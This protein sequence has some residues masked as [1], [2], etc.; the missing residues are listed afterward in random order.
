MSYGIATGGLFGRARAL[1]TPVVINSV[2]YTHFVQFA[3]EPFLGDLA[4]IIVTGEILSVSGTTTKTIVCKRRRMAGSY[5]QQITGQ[6]PQQLQTHFYLG[7][8]IAYTIEPQRYYCSDEPAAGHRGGTRGS[9]A[10][11]SLHLA[12]GLWPILS[13]LAYGSAPDEIDWQG[14]EPEVVVSQVPAAI[15]ELFVRTTPGPWRLNTNDT[16]LYRSGVYRFDLVT[17]FDWVPRDRVIFGGEASYLPPDAALGAHEYWLDEA[18]GQIR[19]SSSMEAIDLDY[20]IIHYE[21]VETWPD[22]ESRVAIRAFNGSGW[23]TALDGFQAAGRFVNADFDIT[24]RIFAQ[25]G[26]AGFGT[27]VVEFR[28]SMGPGALMAGV[29]INT[30]ELSTFIARTAAPGNS[31]N[32]AI[33][34]GAVALNTAHEYV[35]LRIVHDSANEEVEFF[36]TPQGGSESSIG[37]VDAPAGD[38][39]LSVACA[40]VDAVLCQVEGASVEGVEWFAW[41]TQNGAG[42]T[43]VERSRDGSG[44][45]TRRGFDVIGTEPIDFVRNLDTGQVMVQTSGTAGNRNQYRIVSGSPDKIEFFAE[46]D[47]DRIVVAHEASSTPSTAPGRSPA[48]FFPGTINMVDDANPTDLN[49]N[50]ANWRDVIVIDDPHESF[51]GVA[52]DTFEVRG[53]LVFPPGEPQELEY[54]WPDNESSSWTTISSM[55]YVLDHAAGLFLLAAGFVDSLDPIPLDELCFRVRGDRLVHNGSLRAKQVNICSL[56]LNTF[57]DLWVPV[58]LRGSGISVNGNCGVEAG[59]SAME[60]HSSEFGVCARPSARAWGDFP[61]ILP[62]PAAQWPYVADGYIYDRSQA[63]VHDT[64]WVSCGEGAGGWEPGT[65]IQPGLFLGNM[66]FGLDNGGLRFGGQCSHDGGVLVAGAEYNFGSLPIGVPA[67]IAHL[68]SEATIIEAYGKVNFAGVGFLKS[69]ADN[70]TGT[71][72]TFPATSSLRMALVRYRRRA[73]MMR[74]FDGN[75]TTVREIDMASSGVSA[76]FNASTTDGGDVIN[77]LDVLQA[78]YSGRALRGEWGFWPSVAEVNTGNITGYLAGLLPEIQT[79]LDDYDP[80]NPCTPIHSTSAVGLLTSYSSLSISEVMMRIRVPTGILDKRA[81]PL[82]RPALVPY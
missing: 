42:F 63:Y 22:N 57:D 53:R 14:G 2:T 50:R 58:G 74:D 78:V 12:G 56:A 31:A 32:V 45:V 19:L 33:P 55:S 79:E 52:N 20:R 46:A 30:D 68:P 18:T 49:S 29:R 26:A 61:N 59:V 43:A 51:P 37:T 34:G 67:V 76:T 23:G 8:G 66:G 7:G 38:G 47:G 65:L 40:A 41:W 25:G 80:E 81:F 36:V 17:E 69:E 39:Y 24:L 44:L 72:V 77:M 15:N 16:L 13:A 60:C 9:L 27:G 10:G 35:D 28:E 82:V 48:Q 3:P 5:I 71:T 6:K 73:R 11:D 75:P 54:T 70:V 64:S 4:D 1:P 62:Y 21:D